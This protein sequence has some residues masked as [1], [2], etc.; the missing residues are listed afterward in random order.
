MG[1]WECESKA[2]GSDMCAVTVV[3]LT[4]LG[5]FNKWGKKLVTCSTQ[6]KLEKIGGF[7]CHST[8]TLS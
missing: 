1:I 6:L 2:L 3:F 8:K 4:T 7:Q 5:N